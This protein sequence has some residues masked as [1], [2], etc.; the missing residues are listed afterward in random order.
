MEEVRQLVQEEGREARNLVAFHV[1]VDSP[2]SKVARKPPRTLPPA[3]RPAPRASRLRSASAGR[4]KRS[5]LRAR[6]WA[7]LFGDLQ[8]ARNGFRLKWEYDNTPPPQRPQ[9]LAWEIRKT[10]FVKP[11]PKRTYSV[12]SSPT[13]SGKNSPCLSGHNTPSGK[14]SPNLT[15]KASPGS[16]KIS[17]RISSSHSSTSPK[18]N[19]EFFSNKINASKVT[20]K[21]EPKIAKELSRLSDIEEK[22]IKETCEDVPIVKENEN[23]DKD[24]PLK[25][26]SVEIG[27]AKLS[28]S[29]SPKLVVVKSSKS[30]TNTDTKKHNENISCQAK[31]TIDK[32]NAMETEYLQKQ[33]VENKAKNENMLNRDLEIEQ[34]AILK[35]EDKEEI[36]VDDK[37]RELN[38]SPTKSEDNFADVSS[39]SS[40]K[41]VANDKVADVNVN[42]DILENTDEILTEMDIKN[43][44]ENL[45]PPCDDLKMEISTESIIIVTEDKDVVN[46]ENVN[47][48]V[49]ILKETSSNLPMDAKELAE[50]PKTSETIAIQVKDDSNTKEN[51][52]PMDKK[53]EPKPVEDSIAKIE[54][55][56]PS[57]TK[58]N[59]VEKNTSKDQDTKKSEIKPTSKPAYSQAAAKPKVVTNT[60]P[61]VKT[62]V[63][64]ARSST[65]VEIRPPVPK[66]IRP[67]PKKVQTNKCSYP[68]NLTTGR[69]SLFDTTPSPNAN[70]GQVVPRKSTARNIHMAAGD[71]KLVANRPILKARP[72]PTALRVN[73][74]GDK[75]E[76][77]STFLEKVG[78]KNSVP[79]SEMNRIESNESIKTL[80][81]EDLKEDDGVN[82]I[83]VLNVDNK[84]DNDGWLTVKSRRESKKQS[85]TYW[86][87]RFRQPSATASLPT[88]NMLEIA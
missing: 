32:L 22:Y 34:Q 37:D 70:R 75:R 15:G 48:T 36:I 26:K 11:E 87:N 23:K 60:K 45:I 10:D 42:V 20:A 76:K 86:A 67:F 79:N 31:S 69:T 55:L 19:I 54:D 9:S 72:R 25:T 5:E 7:L 52:H 50:K 8:R 68:F 74:K 77:V 40:P 28:P 83:E 3:P 1:A 17:P 44:S 57:P 71:A 66:V 53:D 63:R 6:Y 84:N 46:I 82:S 33:L 16:G 14:N 41:S 24:E 43:D 13:V 29:A 21:P 85:K 51:D 12:K 2:A 27:H 49:T 58:T 59:D 56:S 35:K 62:P 88:L 18:A 38:D 39:D 65:V 61:E 64:L 30:K 73:E 47:E 4:D 80:V 78:R 81:P